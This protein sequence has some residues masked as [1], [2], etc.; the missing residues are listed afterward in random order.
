[1]DA[2]CFGYPDPRSGEEVCVW[3]RLKPNVKLTQDEVI[4]FC[5]GKIAYFKVPKYVKFV[6]GFPINANGK[7]QKMKM[8]E[9]MKKEMEGD[10]KLNNS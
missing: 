2:S 10:A 5:R 8:L 1:M 4:E 6:D 3:I 7:I 9:Q